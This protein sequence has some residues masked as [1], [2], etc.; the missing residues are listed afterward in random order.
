[1]Y[2]ILRWT[3]QVDRTIM[4]HHTCVREWCG[5]FQN[6]RKACSDQGVVGVHI[7]QQRAQ[8]A[9][10]KRSICHRRL[11]ASVKAFAYGNPLA[12]AG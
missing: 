12:I 1:M 9:I 4:V 5:G 3:E 2:L 6:L 7:E 11:T 8:R 10:R